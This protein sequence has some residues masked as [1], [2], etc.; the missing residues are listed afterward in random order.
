MSL[1]VGAV[2]VHAH[3]RSFANHNA[4]AKILI[5]PHLIRQIVDIRGL[6]GLHI[7]FE[8]HLQ[9]THIRSSGCGQ[10]VQLLRVDLGRNVVGEIGVHK[11]DHLGAVVCADY[12]AAHILVDDGRRILL[13]SRAGGKA[14][15][16]GQLG[17]DGDVAQQR[18]RAG[19]HPMLNHGVQHG[20]C[21]AAASA[22]EG[23]RPVGGCGVQHR[24][25]VFNL[26]LRHLIGSVANEVGH[27]NAAGLELVGVDDRVRGNRDGVQR[28]LLVRDLAAG[29]RCTFGLNKR[30][31][32][33]LLYLESGLFTVTDVF[34]ICHLRQPV[35]AGLYHL[36]YRKADKLGDLILVVRVGIRRQIRDLSRRVLR[37]VRIHALALGLRCDQLDQLAVVSDFN[38]TVF[39]LR[40]SLPPV[41]VVTLAIVPPAAGCTASPTASAAYSVES[42]VMITCSPGTRR[43]MRTYL[44]VGSV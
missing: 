5:Q 14:G 44:P 4:C 28:H 18:Y 22:V 37:L 41:V 33:F 31:N 2:G 29:G 24:L 1:S 40:Q 26:L 32:A 12:A 6:G 17:D 23:R 42:T 25:D 39:L 27:L 35:G 10:N 8:N 13:G 11:V 20:L 15:L 34:G 7:A 38:H 16:L 43:F 19:A 21:D 36:I 3:A 30:A 9:R